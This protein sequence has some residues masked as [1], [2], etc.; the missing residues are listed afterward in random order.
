M[1]LRMAVKGLLLDPTTQTPIL[2]LKGQEEESR[3]LPVW[4]GMFEAN[5]IAAELEKVTPARPMTH[6]LLKKVINAV[7]GVVTKMVINDLKEHTY[8]AVIHLLVNGQPI[9][10][11]ARPSDAIAVAL[12]SEAPIFVEEEVLEKAQLLDSA[13]AEAENLKKWLENLGPEDLGNCQV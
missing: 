9:E 10:V 6:D 3:L 5:A 2:I 7:D 8:Y 1:Q 4:I 11:D 12:R 13:E